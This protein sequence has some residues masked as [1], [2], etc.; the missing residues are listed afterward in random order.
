MTPLDG[1]VIEAAGG[2]VWRR[3]G[4][5]LEVLVV[6]RLNRSDWSLPKGK[7]RSDETSEACAVREVAEETGLVCEPGDELVEVAYRDRNGRAKH[8]RYWAMAPG[9]GLAIASG[10]VDE[11]RWATYGEAMD[12]LTKRRDQEVL[13]SLP[14]AR[15][16]A[17]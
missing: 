15:E 3:V 13:A 9:E 7:C 17:A 1:Y 16:V 12:L 6:H 14:C 2:V 5:E 4:R 11:V 8:V 10:E